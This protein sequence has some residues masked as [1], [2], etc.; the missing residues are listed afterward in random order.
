MKQAAALIGAVDQGCKAPLTCD[1]QQALLGIA[2][3]DVVTELD[4]IECLLLQDG[5]ELVVVAPVR[6]GNADVTN[7]TLLF[8]FLQCFQLYLSIT[9]IV[10]L[11]Q[12]NALGT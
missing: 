10:N 5:F 8:P 7:A 3:A 1:R 4:E 12:V 11:H 9:Q 2:V 6:G